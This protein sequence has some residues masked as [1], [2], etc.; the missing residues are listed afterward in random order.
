ML[1]DRVVIRSEA[2][3]HVLFKIFRAYYPNKIP[4]VQPYYEHHHSELEISVIQS[5]AGCYSCSGVDYEFLRG[6]GFMHFGNDI[7][8]FR[9]IGKEEHL[10]LLVIQFEPRFIWTPGGE[11]FD[12][13]YLQ[14]FMG[15]NHNISRHIPFDSPVA[16]KIGRLLSDSFAEC[17]AQLPASDM[18]VKAYLLMVL[19]N[20]ARYFYEALSTGRFPVKTENMVHL[21]HSMDYI[22]SHLEEELTLDLLAREAGMSRSYYST[23]FKMLNGVS[24]WTY[25]INQRID[26][27]QQLL[28][29]SEL[30]VIEICEKCGFHNLSNFN[31]AFKKITGKTPSEYRKE[32]QQP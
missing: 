18:F 2:D 32:L 15:D 22:L 3:D 19:A 16:E 20:L 8:C 10:S 30:S 13:K 9:R 17:R 6:D 4:E 25:I 5:G 14:I 12:S 11:W 29:K 26:R 23:M 31:K 1:K 24:V 28:E 7:H 27:A 21:E